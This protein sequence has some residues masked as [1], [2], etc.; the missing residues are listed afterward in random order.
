[1]PGHCIISAYFFNKAE[2]IKNATQLMA[3]LA[4]T[5][6]LLVSFFN[7]LAEGGADYISWLIL[8]QN[9]DHSENFI[10]KSIDYCLAE[11]S[12]SII[13]LMRYSYYSPLA[14]DCCREG[15]SMA[16]KGNIKFNK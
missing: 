15:L 16:L 12:E 14:V 5:G 3:M 11:V 10:D 2:L 13:I 4:R 7:Q 6:R 1:M 9:G 8:S